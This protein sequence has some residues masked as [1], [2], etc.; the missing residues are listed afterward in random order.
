MNN[1]KKKS[2]KKHALQSRFEAK[3]VTLEEQHFLK[4]IFDD[5]ANRN[6]N[7]KL[8]QHN[9]VLFVSLTGLWADKLFKY[10]ASETD[11]I[12][13]D[14]FLKGISIAMFLTQP[15]RSEPKNN[16]K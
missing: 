9:F 16:R 10:F 4:L 1:N 2:N 3:I 15:Q 11:E 7:G 14:Q 13:F 6:P 8:T 5:L 12:N